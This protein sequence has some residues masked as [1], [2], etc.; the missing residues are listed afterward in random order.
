MT[1]LIGIDIGGTFTDFVVADQDGGVSTHKLLTTPRAPAGAV[2]QGITKLLKGVSSAEVRLVAHAT[3]LATNAIIERRGARV[4][5]LTSQGFSDILTIGRAHRYDMQDLR[6]DLPQPL[7]ERQLIAEVPERLD[8][9]GGQLVPLDEA[10]VTRAVE[11]LVAGGAEALAVGFLHS[12]QDPAHEFR[13]AQL[14]Q[15]LAPQLP[16]SVSSDVAPVIREYERFTTT[17]ANAYVQP[18]VAAYLARL[19]EGLRERDVEAP[20][21][22]MLSN[23]GLADPESAAAFPVRMIESGPAAG[24]TGAARFAASLGLQDCL[25]LDVGG[26]TAKGAVIKGGEPAVSF[27]AEVARLDRFKRGSGLP[28]KSPSV[29]LIEIGAGGGSLASVDTVGRL[30]VG[31]RSA[32]AD[33]GPASYGRGGKDPT[34]TDADVVLGYLNAVK[35]AAGAF[36]LDLQ[37]ARAAVGRTVAGPLGVGTEEAAWGVH[38]VVNENMASAV[39]IHAIERGSDVRSLPMIAFGGCGP[40][41]ACGVAELLEVTTIVIPRAA[42]VFS[43]LGLLVTPPAFETI[44][45]L[46]GELRVLDWDRLREMVAEME[47][48]GIRRVRAAAGG[49]APV[50][51]RR[52]A[53]MRYQGQQ[54]EIT[55]S[56]P[57]G[58]L[59][60]GLVPELEQRFGE[61]YELLYSER[62]DEI[63]VEAVNW[64][65]VVRT[66]PAWS[67]PVPP[68]ATG[69]INEPQPAERRV[70]AFGAAPV[71]APAYA[72]DELVPGQRFTGPAAV[73]G[74]DTTVVVRPGWSA[75]VLPGGHLR[76][77]KAVGGSL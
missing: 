61:A 58:E 75:E 60:A 46:K 54:R 16:I 74:L 4:G 11:Q 17:T 27:D 20:V 65:I 40:V 24:V 15:E 47:A 73:D 35:F 68:E 18:L 10:A 57:D 2:L 56:I 25:V 76:L 23:G 72:W 67:P 55:I 69:D 33:P 66:D 28:I 41:H 36:A 42:S 19:L 77:L 62:M 71:S 6:I 9:D 22:I 59:G 5:F 31:P 30:R 52:S 12:F 7:V 51:I 39:R 49:S 21:V 64:R 8:A 43:A 1:K 45:T 3:T 48:A 13:A 50:L 44:R 70:M 29:D 37:A 26:T 34:V 14:A 32:G 63:P 53:E 38:R